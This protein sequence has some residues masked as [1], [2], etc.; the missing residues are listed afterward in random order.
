MGAGRCI[1]TGAC[2]G[3]FLLQ[4]ACACCTACGVHYIHGNRFDLASVGCGATFVKWSGLDPEMSTSF[5]QPFL[6][7][8]GAAAG[9][10]ATF[11]KWCGLLL[12]TETLELQGD[13][14]RWGF[15]LVLTCPAAVHAMLRSCHSCGGEGQHK[16]MPLRV[17]VHALDTGMKCV[18]SL[19]VL[20][21]AHC[22]LAHPT[23]AQAPR[24]S[25]AMA[26][27]LGV[28]PSIAAASPGLMHRLLG[29]LT[30][31]MGF[32]APY[33]AAIPVICPPALPMRSWR[34]G[35]ATTC[36]PRSTRC[37]WM[38]ASTRRRPCG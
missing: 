34:H 10:G 9:C 31:H 17:E 29:A 35:C 32:L 8:P 18:L 13:Y 33:L 27:S 25:G 19:Q 12:N 5:V 3:I 14:T 23:A 2:V 22:H 38:Q 11:V 28:A 30:P 1:S 6:H 16:N 36:A 21:G 20:R 7:P 26:A 24:R 4:A 37:C 15:A